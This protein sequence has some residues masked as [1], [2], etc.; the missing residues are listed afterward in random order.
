MP[1]RK[2]TFN[3]SVPIR[4]GLFM[5]PSKSG[6]GAYLLGSRCREC[7]QVSFP[8]RAVCSKCFNDE[9]DNIPLSTKGKLYTYSIVRYAPPGLTAPYAIGYIDLPEGVRVFSILTGW[10]NE[11]LKVGMDVELVI[12]KFKEDEEGKTILTYKFKP[13]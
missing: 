9:L 5:L 13:V 10:D 1:D 8:P 4:E 6:E 11:S 3:K 2:E 7:T 12:D